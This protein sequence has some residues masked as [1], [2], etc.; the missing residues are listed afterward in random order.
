MTDFYTRIPNYYC[1]QKRSP[2]LPSEPIGQKV[3]IGDKS[4]KE[5]WKKC[6]N[7]EYTPKHHFCFFFCFVWK[8]RVFFIFWVSVH[9]GE[10]LL[11]N[12]ALVGKPYPVVHWWPSVSAMSWS[13]LL[14]MLSLL[15]KSLNGRVVSVSPGIY[16]R[17]IY[18][19][20]LRLFSF[21]AFFFVSFAEHSS[22]RLCLATLLR[23]TE[24]IFIQPF[25]INFFQRIILWL[26][27]GNVMDNNYV[28]FFHFRIKT[29]EL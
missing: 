27:V 22:F 23:L 5:K 9:A 1:E 19:Y 24:N 29:K 2:K 12:R 28:L 4:L 13:Q 7:M 16:I 6:K 20:F 15:L 26:S 14:L 18:I 11:T 8:N 10:T 21:K 25:K 3:F 17:Y